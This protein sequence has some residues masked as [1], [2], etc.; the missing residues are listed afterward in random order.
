MTSYESLSENHK[1]EII[2]TGSQQ[3]SILGY[4]LLNILLDDLFLV[5]TYSH[6]SNYADD[7]TLYCFDGN[8]NDVDDKLRNDLVQ[9]ME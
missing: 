5:V 3:D 8:I 1:W 4:L 6:L 9:A 7:N 2:I